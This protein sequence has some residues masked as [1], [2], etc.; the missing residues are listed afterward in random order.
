MRVSVSISPEF[1]SS[2]S[3]NTILRSFSFLPFALFAIIFNAANF[4]FELDLKE[5]KF[6]TKVDLNDVDSLGADLCFTSTK[7]LSFKQSLAEYR[8]FKSTQIILEIKFLALSDIF[9]HSSSSNLSSPFLIL[10]IIAV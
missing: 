8:L 5:A 9:C 7:N 3:S 4:N 2:S 6:F 10:L 1:V